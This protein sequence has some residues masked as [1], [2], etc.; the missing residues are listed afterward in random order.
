[1]D[2]PVDRRLSAEVPPRRD[3]ALRLFPFFTTALSALMICLVFVSGVRRGMDH[4]VTFGPQSE[5]NGIAIAISELVYGL[6]AYVGYASVVDALVKKMNG[7]IGAGDQN[8]RTI[9]PRLANAE[10]L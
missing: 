6:D 2:R 5:Q 4:V 9:I 3:L 10:V 7:G 1:M 8:Y